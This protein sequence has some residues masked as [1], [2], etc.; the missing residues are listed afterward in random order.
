[1]AY[2][3]FIL[4]LIALG[5]ANITII[6]FNTQYITGYQAPQAKQYNTLS[7]LLSIIIDVNNCI[8]HKKTNAKDENVNHTNNSWMV[9]AVIK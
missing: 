3:P 7:Y 6:A 9:F 2:P 1:V 8:R 4:L 5:R